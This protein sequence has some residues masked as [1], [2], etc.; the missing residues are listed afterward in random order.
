[1]SLRGR[2]LV[3][4]A[5]LA[6]TYAATA[7][8]VVSTQRSL[9]VDQIDRQLTA[10]PPDVLIGIDRPQL[11]PGSGGSGAR[12]RRGAG[13]AALRVLRRCRRSR[14]ERADLALSALLP[15]TP[16][17]SE[18]V[19]GTDGA[20]GIA[21]IGAGG[22]SS[23]FRAIVLPQS[24]SGPW[25]VAAQSLEQTDAAIARLVR[26][27]WV[28]G[29]VLAAVLAVAFLWVE[30]LGLR[31]IARVTAAAAAITA[32]DRSRRVEVRGQDTEVGKL[33]RAFNLMLDERD[34]S[35]ARLRQFVAD[36]SHELRTPLT[37]VRGYLELYRQGA[38]PR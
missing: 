17:I 27:L 28:A 12:G 35:E 24:A 10:L 21:T 15:G 26:T 8:A 7:I 3:V 34:E 9:L 5:V 19:S 29:A 11:A 33:G 13:R 2:L 25:I 36:A 31:P 37:S 1:V 18:A 16:D 22:T 6:A 20:P 4:I 14:R 30:R 38:F 32:G 23:R